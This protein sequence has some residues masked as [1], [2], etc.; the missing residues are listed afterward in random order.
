M[1]AHIDIS[2]FASAL[3][4]NSEGNMTKKQRVLFTFFLRCSG[5]WRRGTFCVRSAV[6]TQNVAHWN[7]CNATDMWCTTRAN[8]SLIVSTY[9]Y[10]S[11]I[12]IIITVLFYSKDKMPF[13]FSTL[14]RFVHVRHT[15][16]V[17]IFIIMQ[18]M[19]AKPQNFVGFFA[20][21]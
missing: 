11:R 17:T 21:P 2:I 19:Q 3:N 12:V 6:S 13:S 5:S 7:M 4:M 8:H 16:I 18:S 20:Q 10:V 9:I 15:L 1:Y 14:A